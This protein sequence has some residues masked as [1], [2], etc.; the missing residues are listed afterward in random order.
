MSTGVPRALRSTA[1]GCIRRIHSARYENITDYYDFTGRTCCLHCLLPQ[2]AV[3]QSCDTVRWKRYLKRSMPAPM[4]QRVVSWSIRRKTCERA[5]QIRSDQIRCHARRRSTDGSTKWC[6]LSA[7]GFKPTS[8][9]TVELEST[10]LD[11]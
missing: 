4:V 11:R 3:V 7:V 1:F 2:S 6:R 10:P 8:A 9:N 5:E